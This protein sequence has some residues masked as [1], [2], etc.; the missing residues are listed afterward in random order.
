MALKCLR[1]NSTGEGLIKGPAPSPREMALKCLRGNTAGE[2]TPG[3]NETFPTL[4]IDL[5]HRDAARIASVALWLGK[6]SRHFG[7]GRRG[8]WGRSEGQM[9]KVSRHFGEGQRGKRGRSNRRVHTFPTGNG[10]E[11]LE[12]QFRWGR[13]EEQTGKVSHHC[14]EGRSIG[15]GRSLE[16]RNLRSVTWL[17]FTRSGVVSCW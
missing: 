5:P 11:V 9:G 14:G 2:G 4:V 7:E 1:G 6:V 17:V 12:R 3:A 8:K 13:S 15:T 10:P 16:I